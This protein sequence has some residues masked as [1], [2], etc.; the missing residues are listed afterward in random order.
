MT[1]P[2]SIV[3]AS[4]CASMAAMIIWGGFFGFAGAFALALLLREVWVHEERRG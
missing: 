2:W 3:I 1:L 4:A